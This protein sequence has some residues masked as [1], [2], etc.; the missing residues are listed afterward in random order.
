MLTWAFAMGAHV[1]AHRGRALAAARMRSTSFACPGDSS[2]Q[3]PQGR[4]HPAW[5]ASDNRAIY[6]PRLQAPGA[7]AMVSPLLPSDPQ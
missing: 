7:T 6:L 1:L 4:P 3:L 5:L 2:C